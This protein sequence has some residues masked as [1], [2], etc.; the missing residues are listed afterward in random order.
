MYDFIRWEDVKEYA[1]PLKLGESTY[2]PHHGCTPNN[3]LW[4]LHHRDGYNFYCN[5]CSAKGYKR[6]GILSFSELALRNVEDEETFS[7]VVELP[8]DI[9]YDVKSWP[10]DARVWLY[11]ADV[12]D[13]QIKEYGIG[14]SPKLHRVILPVYNE[15]KKLLMWQGRGLSEH[16][17][18]Y[19]NVFGYGRN[20]LLFKSWIKDTS[21]TTPNK[22]LIVVTEDILSAIRVGSVTPSVASLGTSLSLAQINVLG[23]YDKVIIWYDDDKGGK[24][25]SLKGLNKLKVITEVVTVRTNQDPKKLS[26]QE[27]E[28]VVYD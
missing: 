2:A 24:M 28:E 11:L 4:I 3:K 21:I 25:G 7:K 12:R 18:K 17:T 19:Y 27:I 22:D 23:K 26:K 14:Y 6:K 15:N 1:T 10:I 20:E 16:Q 13:K 9:N 5:K 8:E